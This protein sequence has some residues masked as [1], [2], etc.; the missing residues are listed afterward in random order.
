MIGILAGFAGK[1]G[2]DLTRVQARNR[3]G[4]HIIYARHQIDCLLPLWQHH[5]RYITLE[6][7]DMVQ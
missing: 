7:M 2:F 3:S 1:K 5:F 4:G 6:N